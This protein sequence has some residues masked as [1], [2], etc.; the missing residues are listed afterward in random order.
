[1]T[2]LFMD[3]FDIGDRAIRYASGGNG[4]LSGTNTRFNYGLAL[5][6]NSTGTLSTF[7]FTAASQVFVGAA[8]DL[9]RNRHSIRFLGDARATSHITVNFFTDGSIEIRRGTATGTVIASA[10]AGTIA[11]S[12]WH[13]VEVSCTISDT[14]GQ[15]DVR[16]DGASTAI[17]SFTGDTKN[18]GTNT[19]ID[20]V[21]FDSNGT[22]SCA[23]DDLYILNSSG[24][25]N[26]TFL[27]DVRVY[28]L[29]A[30]GNGN[31]SQLVGSD[32]NSTDN[33]L[34]VDEKPYSATDYTG[35]ATIGDKDSYVMEDLPAGVTT[36]FAVQEVAIAAKSDAGAGSLKQLIRRSSTDYL[37]AAKALTTAYAPYLNLRETDPSTSTAWTASGVN[38]TEAGI[39]VA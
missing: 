10:I 6:Y 25:T 8:F 11:P 13:Y 30:N 1:M 15:V 5:T 32:G 20:G 3:G 27:G 21:A 36:V 28:A 2:L 34:L 18:A 35:S 26:N 37:T 12:V 19:T 29:A 7:A 9:A 4:T 14:V 24:S 17:L 31:Y 23:M 38:A 33:Y 22:T 16:V 39:E